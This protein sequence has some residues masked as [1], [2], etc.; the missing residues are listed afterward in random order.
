[1]DLEINADDISFLWKGFSDSLADFV[2]ETTK[3]MVNLNKL[4]YN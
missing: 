4:T 2:L 3:N 1:M